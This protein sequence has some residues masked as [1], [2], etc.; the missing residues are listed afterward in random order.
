LPVS[1]EILVSHVRSID[2]PTRPI[3]ALGARVP[4]AIL[5][6]ARAK[7]AASMGIDRPG[8]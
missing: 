3:A 6:E 7:L 1:G 8:G 5:A 4:S 2:T